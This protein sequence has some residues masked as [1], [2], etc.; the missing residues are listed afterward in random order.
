MHQNTAI[1]LAMFGTTVESALE[2][3]LRIKQAVTTAYPNTPV[4]L[5]FTSNQIRRIWQQ[6]AASPQYKADHPDIPDEILSIQGLL[7]AIANLQDSGHSRLVIQPTHITA[8]EEFH[9]LL[10][11]VRGLM[12][13][14][15]MKPKWQPFDTITV[16]RPLLGT[17]SPQRPYTDDIEAMAAALQSDADLAR[18]HQAALVYM[19]HGNHFFPSGGLYLELAARMRHMYPD[20]PAF[21]GTLEGFPTL[22]DI[23]PD[24]RR[25]NIQRVILKPLLVVA[26][27]HAI[28]DMVGTKDSWQVRLE[29][30]GLQVIPVI[31]G[32]SE[33][34]EV[35]QIFVSH[36]ADAAADVGIELG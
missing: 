11:Y 9:D 12:A 27:G 20:T 28:H 36:L 30:E 3:F 15:T 14:R 22:E 26:G 16:G 2:G 1:V 18:S 31:K 19:G 21:I 35:L 24:L 13:I 17:Y 33:Q 29:Q 23:L 32:L 8:A 5:A 6:R 10:S 4:R 34:D 25:L 7:A